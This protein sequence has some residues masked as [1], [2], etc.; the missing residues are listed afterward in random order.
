MTHKIIDTPEMTVGVGG[1]N[2]STELSKLKDMTA[3]ITPIAKEEFE[4]RIEN[5]CDLMR[6]NDINAVYLNAGTNLY[7]FTGTR[8]GA[9][10][11]MVGAILTRQ[12]QVHYIAPRFE[13]STL[14]GFM[15]IKGQVHGWE[16]H[17][18]P[19]NLFGSVL[20]DL[21]IIEG[22]IGLDESCPFF[23]SN[24]LAQA[25]PSYQ[26]VSAKSITAGCRM[27]KS[28][29]ELALMQ[30]AKN[31]TLEV[32][33]AAA[34]ILHDGISTEE[35]TEFIHAAHKKV[36]ATKGSYFCIVLFGEDSAYPHGV[37]NPKA[38]EKNDMVLIDTG[39]QLHGYNSDIT[40]TYVFGVPTQRD[41]E[42]WN[43]EK[44][45]QAIG[46]KAA[47][48]G[49]SCGAV[50]EAARGYLIKQ[51]YGPGY[52]AP[53]LVHRTGHG[54]GLDIH[55]WPYLVS[56]DT[57]PLQVGMCFSNE[58]MISIPGEFGVRLED[59]F[60]MTESGPKWFTEPSHSLDDPFG[61]QDQA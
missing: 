12:G 60:Y 29:A 14:S 48:L 25:H 20:N 10:E 53:G 61:Y 11:R 30:R 46:F 7:Y 32:H 5:A 52:Q 33:K 3:G 31:M 27:C 47:Q 6:D 24:G 16:E 18:S 26:Y 22:N 34:R 28:E 57:T 44:E 55:E 39:C 43:Q 8:W 37:N 17:E 21:G 56:S 36:G 42:V 40:R 2:A 15:L 9:S 4:Q 1:S 35:V 13:I 23:I 41:R 58:P 38:L 45:S 19:Y 50:D 54:I 49:V 51:G 59:H